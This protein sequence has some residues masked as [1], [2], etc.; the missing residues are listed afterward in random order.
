MIGDDAILGLRDI[1]GATCEIHPHD[2]R[3]GP[4][5]SIFPP[6]I[7]CKVDQNQVALNALFGIAAR[8]A[9]TEW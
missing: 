4:S 9:W 8:E 6:H 5:T 3:R 2:L 1:A 7:S